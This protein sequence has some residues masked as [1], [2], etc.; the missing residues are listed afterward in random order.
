MKKNRIRF[1]CQKCGKEFEVPYSETYRRKA[2]VKYCS[3]AC[4]QA[5]RWGYNGKCQNC[6]KPTNTKFCSNECQKE[7]WNKHGY[8]L[9]KKNRYW[10]RK[11][12]LIKSLGG[13]CV[14]CGNDDIRVLDIHHIDQSK[15]IVPKNRQYAW[16]RRFKDW[17]ANRGNLEILCANCHRIHTWEQM[18]YGQSNGKRICC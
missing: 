9:Q 13:K 17:E 3:M 10:E 14:V 4:Y 16:T 11:I 2:G 7:Y 5:A 12:E 6:G 15:K 8:E 1:I 18:G